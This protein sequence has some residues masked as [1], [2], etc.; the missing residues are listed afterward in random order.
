MTTS[1]SDASSSTDAPDEDSR[2]HALSDVSSSSSEA[3]TFSQNPTP[4]SP[5]NRTS[6]APQQRRRHRPPHME[7]ISESPWDT[8]SVVDRTVNHENDAFDQDY[9]QDHHQQHQQQEQIGENT[10]IIYSNQDSSSLPGRSSSSSNTH[11]RLRR[12]RSEEDDS[13]GSG[14]G[15]GGSLDRNLRRDGRNNASISG[16]SLALRRNN[17]QRRNVRR[18]RSNHRDN[19]EPTG[20]R[21]RDM[22][23]TAES[24]GISLSPLSA[25]LDAGMA[26]LRRW[27]RSRRTSVGSGGAG[28]NSEQRSLST[29]SLPEI[30]LG[31]QDIAALSH[32]G[33]E[34]FGRG[35]SSLSN[36]SNVLEP[37]S[38]GNSGYIYYRP[39]EVEVDPNNEVDT[40][41]G[42]DDESGTHPLVQ[43]QEDATERRT[44]AANTAARRRAFS[45]PDRA[46]LIDFLSSVYGSRVIDG[47]RMNMR[48]RYL[49]NIRPNTVQQATEEQANV[50]TPR[51]VF[52]AAATSSV[53]I[54]EDNLSSQNALAQVSSDHGASMHESTVTTDEQP[55]TSLVEMNAIP[56]TR[57]INSSSVNVLDPSSDPNRRARSRW[58]Q[59]NRR[60]QLTIKIVALL[61]SLLL[62]GILVCW[63][64][65]ITCYVIS[66]DQ[67]CDVP[68]K[69]YFWLSTL[70]LVL[71]IFRADITKWMCRYRSDSRERVPPR[72]I[73][74]NFVYLVYAIMIL[75]LGVRCVFLSG[76]PSCAS[77]APELYFVSTVFVCLNLAAWATIFMGYLV[78]FCVVAFLLT[79]NGYFP[80]ANNSLSPSG[81]IGG[82][83]GR[84]GIGIMPSGIVEFPNAYSNPAP[85]GCIELMRVVLLDEFPASYPKECCVSI[86]VRLSVF[87]L[88][89]SALTY[90]ALFSNYISALD[91]H[92]GVYSRRSHCSNSM[93]THISQTMLP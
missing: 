77:T 83:R 16:S 40:T 25:S 52:F 46:R 26:A 12:N 66:L 84:V 24:R 32:A 87:F 22:D 64:F 85:F 76:S 35:T 6:G 58:I 89:R 54:E 90:S 56:S 47:R 19:N 27:I 42:S 88:F 57:N 31:E 34:Q 13:W 78:P 8:A 79:W 62:F 18:L 65:L 82:G 10:N 29:S 61:F 30:R 70:Q 1:K 39:Y 55:T 20:E 73:F 71:D 15:A 5:H 92:D 50:T 44:A 93:P 68:L 48:R 9:G 86:S 38:S 63:V 37:S 28:S 43:Q 75:R 80:N 74:Y 7:S 45:E 69:A 11:T 81:G 49:S 4:G 33:D 59:I 21:D 3:T 17:Q 36:S 51:R 72:V 41:Y 91:L 14:S 23:Q 2:M 53:E 67:V 60:F